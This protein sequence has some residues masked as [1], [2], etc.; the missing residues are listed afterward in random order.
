[1]SYQPGFNIVLGNKEIEFNDVVDFTL[2]T[3][4]F[5]LGQDLF[6][7]IR[8]LLNP[9]QTKAIEER[10]EVL[11]DVLYHDV[12]LVLG[13]N[14]SKNDLRTTPLNVPNNM[15]TLVELYDGYITSYTK[16]GSVPLEGLLSSVVHHRVNR[17]ETVASHGFI[18]RLYKLV[19]SGLLYDLIT[20]DTLAEEG[21]PVDHLNIPPVL[22]AALLAEG[23]GKTMNAIMNSITNMFC[24][25]LPTEELIKG[26]NEI[27]RYLVGRVLE[28]G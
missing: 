15:S 10:L 24:L 27:D 8:R 1:M 4:E 9:I 28:L 7:K 17:S 3:S 13:L 12:S 23:L 2:I 14:V 20:Y 11:I 18:V 6:N 5:T 25:T 19:D 26:V 22:K 16:S 21:K